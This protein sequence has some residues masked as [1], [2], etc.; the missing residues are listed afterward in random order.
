MHPFCEMPPM[1]K[2]TKEIVSKV[3]HAEKLIRENIR[4]GRITKIEL[5]DELP[6]YW[7]D[8]LLI[9]YIEE[10][11]KRDLQSGYSLQDLEVLR[12]LYLN[13]KLIV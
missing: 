11:E 8:L 7:R 13:V 12:E 3:L 4:E 10:C 6:A 2:A 1:G 5:L 9:L